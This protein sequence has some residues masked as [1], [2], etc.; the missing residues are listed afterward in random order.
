MENLAQAAEILPTLLFA[1]DIDALDEEK[2]ELKAMVKI[3]K[4]NLYQA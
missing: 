1:E 3:L 4:E 2:Q